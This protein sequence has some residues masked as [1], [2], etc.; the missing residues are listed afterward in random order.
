MLLIRSWMETYQHRVRPCSAKTGNM[1]TSMEGCLL[2]TARMSKAPNESK[3]KNCFVIQSERWNSH[4]NHKLIGS[5]LR[6]PWPKG[7]GSGEAKLLEGHKHNDCIRLWC[8]KLEQ[9]T[10][11]HI[12]QIEAVNDSNLSWLHQEQVQHST[13]SPLTQ[14]NSAKSIPLLDLW[15][16][17]PSC[18]PLL[19]MCFAWANRHMAHMFYHQWYLL[20]WAQNN[21]SYQQEPRNE[22]QHFHAAAATAHPELRRQLI[23]AIIRYTFINIAWGKKKQKTYGI[24]TTFI[25]WKTMVIWKSE[26]EM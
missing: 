15:H 4:S 18:N 24:W 12:K 20:S 26:S 7:G 2:T 10:H 9:Y 23:T 11:T 6:L 5:Q 21:L 8:T 17:W 22:P 1:R 13:I 3:W 16:C 25:C 19:P 14:L